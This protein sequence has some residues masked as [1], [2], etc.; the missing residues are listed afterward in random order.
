M[1]AKLLKGMDGTTMEGDNQNKLQQISNKDL[2]YVF[3]QNR[4][5][6]PAKPYYEDGNPDMYLKENIEKRKT[7]QHNETVLEAVNDFMKEFRQ[8]GQGHISKDEYFR[9]FINVGMILRPG[10]D[11]D[12]LQKIIKEEFDNDTSDAKQ[13]FVSEEEQKAQ[14]EIDQKNQQAQMSAPKTYDYIDQTKLQRALFELADTWCPNIDE[15]EYKEFFQQLKF[16]LKYAGQ[17]DTSA[18]DVL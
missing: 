8:N 18:Y 1:A 11:A 2:A 13:M 10:I 17:Q 12:D 4:D 15:F 16:R 3:L 14:A 9:V 5:N 6:F 7:L